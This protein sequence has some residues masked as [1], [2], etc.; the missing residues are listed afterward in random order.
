[1]NITRKSIS[2]APARYGT[3]QNTK[4]SWSKKSP[5]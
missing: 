5:I 3:M 1:M 4:S 2:A